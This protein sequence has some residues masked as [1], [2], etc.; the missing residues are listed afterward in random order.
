MKKK[1]KPGKY[2]KSLGWKRDKSFD[3][4]DCKYYVF[5]HNVHGEYQ[6]YVGKKDYYLSDD[7][8]ELECDLEKLTKP[9][10]DRIHNEFINKGVKSY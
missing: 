9:T 7:S 5:Y 8:D 10:I 4:D 2:L 6:M 1:F 3:G